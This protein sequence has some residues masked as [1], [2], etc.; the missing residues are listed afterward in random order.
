[1]ENETKDPRRDKKLL[2]VFL[3]PETFQ[4]V[5]KIPMMLSVGS[6]SNSILQVSTQ[7]PGGSGV[8]MGRRK[9]I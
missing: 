1:M 9:E 3:L 5:D 2:Q 8:K 7:L 4:K 6:E